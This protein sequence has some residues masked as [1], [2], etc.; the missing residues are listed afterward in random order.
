MIILTDA[1]GGVIRGEPAGI[2]L[3]GPAPS[4]LVVVAEL[5]TFPQES[6]VELA[7]NRCHRAA[8]SGRAWEKVCE[9][10]L[11]AKYMKKQAPYGTWRS[12]LA[13]ADLASSAI[14]LNYVQVAAGQ[15]SDGQVSEG[16]P[17]WVESRPAE[18][19]RNV[20]VTSAAGGAVRELT[21][22]GFNARTRVHEYGGTPY[23]MSHGTVYFSNFTDQRLYFQRPGEAPVALTPAGYRYADFEFDSRGADCFVCEKITPAGARPKTLSC[24][25]DHCRRWLLHLDASGSSTTFG[26]HAS[27]VGHIGHFGR[28]GHV[29]RLGRGQGAVR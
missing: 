13:A 15:V 27:R 5:L 14:S 10:S 1:A 8:P 24:C 19:G 21:P 3:C 7:A 17:Y 22:P 2:I 9:W 26:T 25:R 29:G 23:V 11:E 28:L 4:G 20:V 12:A 6:I 18:G 16:I